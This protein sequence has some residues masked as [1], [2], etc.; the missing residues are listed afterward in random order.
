[1]KRAYDSMVPGVLFTHESCWIQRMSVKTFDESL[2]RITKAVADYAPLYWHMDDICGYARAK[3][4][5]K[6][7]SASAD[8]N[9]A[10]TL[11]LDGN[12]DRETFCFVFTET[13]NGEITKS[14]KS[15]PQVTGQTNAK[16]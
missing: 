2:K 12:N 16:I 10:L 3:H 13:Q 4:D 5:M 6:I 11:T 7:T 9:G 8:S 1:L 15:L 14:M